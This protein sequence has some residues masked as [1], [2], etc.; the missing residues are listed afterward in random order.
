M[1]ELKNYNFVEILKN[2]INL[3]MP[4]LF[5]PI[6]NKPYKRERVLHSLTLTHIYLLTHSRALTLIHSLA[7]T[8][9]HTDLHLLNNQLTR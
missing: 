4:V 2:T 3:I 6:L 7:L 8:F 5:N 9:I 1:G